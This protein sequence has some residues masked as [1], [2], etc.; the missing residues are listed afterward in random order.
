M[1]N[2]ESAGSEV[3]DPTRKAKKSV[4]EVRVMLGP[5]LASVNAISRGTGMLSLTS[6][7]ESR[8]FTITNMSS[9]PRP[10]P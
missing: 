1:E 5:A 2:L 4:R 3:L 6:G 10:A 8:L 7:S 9:T